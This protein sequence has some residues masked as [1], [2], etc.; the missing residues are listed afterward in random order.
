[1]APFFA[2]RYAIKRRRR[3]AF[4]RYMHGWRMV[5]D[6]RRATKGGRMTDI[7]D[8]AVE[9]A[10]KARYEWTRTGDAP[11]PS[12]TWAKISEG[13]REQMRVTERKALTAAYPKLLAE[14][15]RLRAEK[16]EGWRGAEAE[17]ARLRAQVEAVRE[18]CVQA[19]YAYVETSFILG[20]LS[21]EGKPDAHTD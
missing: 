2:V 16:A 21:D 17:N 19:D 11:W 3:G 20:A 15:Q 7:P 10:A 8:E 9:A 14:V 13:A 5:R 12:P 6:Y 18:L 1:M 4:G